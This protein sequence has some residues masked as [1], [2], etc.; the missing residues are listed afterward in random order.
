MAADL[1]YAKFAVFVGDNRTFSVTFGIPSA[2][3]EMRAL[4]K[5]GPFTAA[6]ASLPV[7]RPWIDPVRSE[8][9]T[10]VEIMAG[11]LNRRR[12]LVR[13]GRPVVTGLFAV[14]DSNICTN[15]LYGR[16]CSLAMVQAYSLADV[17]ETAG[18]DTEHAALSFAAAT[19]RDIEPWYL[20]SVEQDKADDSARSLVRDGVMA[21][22][23]TDPRVYRAFLRAFNLLVA[24]N[25]L[26]N[27]AD[28]VAS[29]LAAYQERDTRP[30]RIPSDPTSTACGRYS[31]RPPTH[32]RVMYPGTHA[33]TTPDK[34]AYIMGGTGEI[35]TYR[36]LDERSNQLAQLLRAAGPAPG[37][38]I[39]SV[40]ENNARFLESPGP[41]SARAST[42]R[43]S[44]RG[45]PR[46]GRLHR[47]RLRGPGVH[48]LDRPGRRGRRARRP[49]AQRARPALMID[50]VDRRLRVLRGRGRR[51][52]RRRR[53]PTS[54][55][56]ADMLYS[57]GTTGRPK[58]VKRAAA[59]RRR[60]TAPSAVTGL[61][62]AALRHRPTTRV[63][64][65]PAPL[66]HAAPLR[67]TMAVH[68]AR[69]HRRRHGALRPG[70][71]PAPRSS[72]TRSRTPSSCRRCSCAC[73]SCPTRCA[74]AYDV[75]SPAG[76]SSTP[77]RRARSPVKEQMIEWWG[78]IIHEYYAGT[79]G[80]G[81]VVL[82]LRGVAGPPG[83]GRASR[84]LGVVH[85]V[86]EDGDGAAGRRV[87]ARSTSTGGAEFEY[88]NDPEKTDGVAPRRTGWTTLGDIGY[89][90]DDGFLYL[91]DRKAYMIISRR[92]EHLSAGGRERP[93][94][95]SRR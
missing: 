78:P 85:I 52:A 59:R 4:L 82:Q 53:S 31:S 66:Y 14:G 75:S 56:G 27:D 83:H 5:P 44:A 8:P 3:H 79:E 2:D 80:N 42:T 86:D 62:P 57:S 20:A 28:V 60:S 34:P 49:H 84:S 21:A 33:Q 61:A 17:V 81:F 23:G 63:Y 87:R 7:V 69:R 36:Q 71:V 12:H 30:A 37:D 90:D 70:G 58:G 41:R 91:T 68:R 25:A 24:P 93:V 19:S 74:T 29:V 11:L 77:P 51:A 15:P 47:Q 65:S 95:A 38:P 6:A 50:G 88:H 94:D 26:M 54:V 92:R 45:S 46:R 64:L 89:L 18:D 10:G 32:R 43:R 48:H 9:I 16:G 1:G 76:A 67:F 40:L 39:A 35:V 22:A 73:S 55:E 72:S 13:D